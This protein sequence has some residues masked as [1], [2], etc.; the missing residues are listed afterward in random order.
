MTDPLVDGGDM[1]LRRLAAGDAEPILVAD[2]Q[3]FSSA[4]RLS[5]LVCNSAPGRPVYQV[6]PLAALSQDRPY[7][8]LA[9]LAAEA[10]DSF[11]RSQPA[12]GPAYVI[13]YCSASALA[14]HIATLLAR[15]REAT[16]VLLRPSWP[17]T[18][19]VE[20]TFSTLAANM[21]APQLPCPELDGDPD[22]SVRSMEEQ[23]AEQ[24]AVLTSSQG[25]DASADTFGELLL[26]YRSWLAFL[27]ACSN[28]SRADTADGPSTVTVLAEAP[29]SVTVPGL[30]AGRFKVYPLPVLDDENPVTPEV[31]ELLA[32]QLLSRPDPSDGC[33]NHPA[34]GGWLPQ[35]SAQVGGLRGRVGGARAG[36]LRG[37]KVRG[38]GGARPGRCAARGRGGGVRGGVM[39]PGKCAA[40]V[41]GGGVARG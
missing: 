33:D 29:D 34:I 7:I 12:D 3:A 26:T 41:C 27:L 2:F 6:D 19:S 32:A 11:A 10:A 21:G 17:S 38:R 22:R 23:L 18:Q 36:G 37:R 25:L 28:D 24:L 4:P 20:E 31:V 14:L 30:P 1:L 15:S 5:Q 39:R 16:A 9:D 35:P 8:S 13:G 40:G